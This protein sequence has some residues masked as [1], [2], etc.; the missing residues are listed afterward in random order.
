MWIGFLYT[1]MDRD[2]FWS[3]VT[4]MHKHGIEPPALESPA[5]NLIALSMMLVCFQE[6][7]FMFYVLYY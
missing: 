3:D 6:V 4:T 2:L 1:L 5:V 7:L